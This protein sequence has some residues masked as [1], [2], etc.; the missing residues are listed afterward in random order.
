MN[1][2]TT[3]IHFA[4]EFGGKGR[5]TGSRYQA[6]V[7]VTGL[8]LSKLGVDGDYHSWAAHGFP[9]NAGEHLRVLHRKLLSD[10]LRLEPGD[11]AGCFAQG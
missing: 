10:E 8:G 2:H 6:A 7:H 4:I 11:E 1:C 9:A 3:G 5:A